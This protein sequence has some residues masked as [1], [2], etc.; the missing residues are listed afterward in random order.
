MY[1][2]KC[3]AQ[4]EDA[5]VNCVQCGDVLKKAPDPA[6]AQQAPIQVSNYLVQSILVT[7]FCCLPFGIVAIVYAA[8]VNGKI[9]MGDAQGAIDY[10][11]KARNWSWASFWIGFIPG[12][13]YLIL[14]L[15]RGVSRL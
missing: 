8:Q 13:L 9:Q 14:V 1:C 2:W 4:N 7:V 11:R 6:A 10:S 3:G 15:I 5:A 12:V